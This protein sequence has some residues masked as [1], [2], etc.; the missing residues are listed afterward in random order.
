MVSTDKTGVCPGC[1]VATIGY[2]GREGAVAAGPVV[3]RD[4]VEVLVERRLRLLPNYV[5]NRVNGREPVCVHKRRVVRRLVVRSG[6][7]EE[8]AERVDLVFAL[9]DGLVVDGP[10]MVTD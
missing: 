10:N 7:L 3:V 8:P 1:V 5:E 2:G 9:K 4:Q 6:E